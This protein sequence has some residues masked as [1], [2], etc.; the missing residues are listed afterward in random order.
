MW[1]AFFAFVWLAG[2]FLVWA[3]TPATP[4]PHPTPT[5]AATRTP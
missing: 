3:P 1:E 5:P 2:L 4:D